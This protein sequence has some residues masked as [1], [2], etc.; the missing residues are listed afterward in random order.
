M[1][2]LAGKALRRL[3]L[4]LLG[5]WPRILI[6]APASSID[7]ADKKFATKGRKLL[8]RARLQIDSLNR[9]LCLGRCWVGSIQRSPAIVQLNHG[10]QLDREYTAPRKLLLCEELLSLT[11]TGYWMKHSALAPGLTS[12]LIKKKSPSFFIFHHE[13][14]HDSKMLVKNN[15]MFF[16][17]KFSFFLTTKLRLL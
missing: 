10:A 6:S 14:L 9:G 15:S 13:N 11:P 17:N 5:V 16:E 7:S 3:T 4:A 8:S 12:S 1:E 2:D